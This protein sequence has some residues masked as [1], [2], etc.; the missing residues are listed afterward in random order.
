MSRPP[1]GSIAF[2]NIPWYS[3]LIASGLVV[4]LFIALASEKRLGLKKDTVV[5]F[6]LCGVPLGII[7]ARIYYIAFN[8]D[9]YAGSFSRMIRINE[10][11]LAIYGGII[12]GFVVAVVVSRVKKVSLAL[13]L[14]VVAPSMILAQGIGRW[15]NYA[16]MEAFGSL[17]TN[18]AFQFFPISVEIFE[19][20]AWQWHMATFFYES[21]WCALSFVALQMLSHRKHNTGDVF[22]WYLIL[23]GFERTIVEGFRADS[24]TFAGGLRVS[25]LLSAALVVVSLVVYIMRQKN[26]KREISI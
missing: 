5:D 6:M 1:L 13:L 25:Q 12:V 8:W 9:Y 14:D 16:N 11:G 19:N 26:V 15:G 3:L 17:I 4:G 21:L 23:Y 7:G 18:P 2:L 24:L 22:L 20:G 10:G